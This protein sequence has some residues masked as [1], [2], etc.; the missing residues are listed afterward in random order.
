MVFTKFL[1]KC[2]DARLVTLS[3]FPA[4]SPRP[5]LLDA[6]PAE[7][8]VTAKKRKRCK[9][10]YRAQLPSPPCRAEPATFVEYV[11]R[12][13]HH[14]RRLLRDCDLTETFPQA[15][16]SL[17]CSSGTLNEGTDGG[18]LNGLGTFGFVWRVATQA[19]APT[20]R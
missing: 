17:I 5:Q 1:P 13:P 10:V 6:V 15:F 8:Q 14:V 11:A 20:N 9:I 16:V 12:Q 7:M 3:G 2:P 19:D 4:V 18:F